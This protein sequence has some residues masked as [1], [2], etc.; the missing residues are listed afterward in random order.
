MTL[1]KKMTRFEWKKERN[2]IWSAFSWIFENKKQPSR[3]NFKTR[4]VIVKIGYFATNNIKRWGICCFLCCKIHVLVTFFSELVKIVYFRRFSDICLV[5]LWYCLVNLWLPYIG[6][7]G[8][9]YIYTYIS[10][11]CMRTHCALTRSF[12]KTKKTPPKQPRS[13]PKSL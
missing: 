10:L 3:K 12:L 13:A 6:I 5:N 8:A 7:M 2:G 1:E 9:A 4:N 11:S